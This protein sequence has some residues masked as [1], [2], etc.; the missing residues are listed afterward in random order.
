MTTTLGDATPAE[1][2][3]LDGIPHTVRVIATNAGGDGPSSKR[4][5]RQAEAGAW[6]GPQQGQM[7]MWW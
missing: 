1:D 7:M 2:T 3:A 4:S 6:W 5:H